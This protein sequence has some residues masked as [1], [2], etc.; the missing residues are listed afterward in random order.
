M[1]RYLKTVGGIIWIV[2]EIPWYFDNIEGCICCKASVIRRIWEVPVKLEGQESRLSTPE[3]GLNSQ[4]LQQRYVWLYVHEG[5]RKRD[6]RMRR[7]EVSYICLHWLLDLKSI[8]GVKK[9]HSALC[10]LCWVPETKLWSKQVYDCALYS[11]L[12]HF[13][14][15]IHFWGFVGQ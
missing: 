5:E 7:G 9:L 14:L 4:W 2:V 13:H 8:W 10:G 6:K 15:F 1:W 12:F 11:Q 3:M